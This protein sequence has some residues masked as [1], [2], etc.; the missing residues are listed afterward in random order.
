VDAAGAFTL[1]FG[2]TMV[3][4]MANPITGSDI[5]ATLS[6]QGTIQDANLWCGSVTGMVTSPITQD[7]MGSTFAAVRVEATDPASLPTDVLSTCPA[8]GGGGESGDSGGSDSGG[9]TG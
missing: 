9:T 5:A 3:T 7:L 1:D 8:G 4:G 6:L 2:D